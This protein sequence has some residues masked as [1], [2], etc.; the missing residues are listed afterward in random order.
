MKTFLKS[1]F[2]FL[3]VLVLTGTLYAMAES[4]PKDCVITCENCGSIEVNHTHMDD[5]MVF[6]FC[7]DCKHQ[8]TIPNPNN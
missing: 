3:P 6:Y 1:V 5:N 8:N 4:C 7:R 2:A